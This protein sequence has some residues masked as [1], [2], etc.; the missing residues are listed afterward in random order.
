MGAIVCHDPAQIRAPCRTG[1]S[2]VWT[3]SICYNC[4]QS[5]VIDCSQDILPFL[6]YMPPFPAHFVVPVDYTKRHHVQS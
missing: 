5:D 3:T 1:G 2:F 4:K 6:Y